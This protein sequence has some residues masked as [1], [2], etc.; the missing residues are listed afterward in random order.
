MRIEPTTFA[1]GT[2]ALPSARASR[3]MRCMITHA[4]HGT[5]TRHGFPVRSHRRGLCAR[6]KPRAREPRDLRG[7]RRGGGRWGRWPPEVQR[8]LEL[9]PRSLPGAAAGLSAHGLQADTRRPV[10]RPL[11]APRWALAEGAPLAQPRLPKTC[12]VP[13]CVRVALG[14]NAAFGSAAAQ[15]CCSV[16]SLRCE[17]GGACARDPPP[18]TTSR[19]RSVRERALCDMLQLRRQALLKRCQR[20]AHGGAPGGA[21]A[22]PTWCPRRRARGAQA[23]PMRVLGDA[24]AV[25]R[26]H[27]SARRRCPICAQA[28]P[29]QPSSYEIPR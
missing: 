17:S 28:V 23:V 4:S 5:G 15:W 18:L 9:I 25:P 29:K 7:P 14:V 8:L 6:R 12:S 1:L 10:H 21:K 2:Y 26:R 22:A 24:C 16:H 3:L 20:G 13:V 19:A 11:P 27:P